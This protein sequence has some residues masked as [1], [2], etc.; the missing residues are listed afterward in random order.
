[1]K[2]KEQN[3]SD[4]SK[5]IYLIYGQTNDDF[6]EPSLEDLTLNE[7][8]YLHLK[9]LEYERI[10]Y[11]NLSRKLFFF[12]VKSKTT[13]KNVE[14]PP[15][16]TNKF[17][18]SIVSGPLGGALPV[19]H[20]ESLEPVNNT[21]TLHFGKMSD[22]HALKRINAVLHDT[23]S[24]TA[25]I[26]ENADDYIRFFNGPNLHTLGSY[27][28]SWEQL[29]KENQ[30]I[31][32]LVFPT[33][34]S[35]QDIV[36][37]YQ[38]HSVFDTY[39]KKYLQKT[40]KENTVEIK[41]PVKAEMRNVC[42]YLRIVYKVPFE[43]REFDQVIDYLYKYVMSEGCSLKEITMQLIYNKSSEKI[44]IAYLQKLFP[45]DFSEDVIMEINSLIGQNNFKEEVHKLIKKS[46]KVNKSYV[47]NEL[48]FH[49]R[50]THKKT[51]K[52]K[53]E[54]NL[55][56]ALLG[57]P[58]T[59][60]T[61]VAKKMGQL[62]AKLGYLPSG[63]L[64]KATRADLV[65]E[66]V[67]HTAPK[68]QK[69][70]NR[71][72]GGVLFIDEVYSLYKGEN[73][74]FGKECID[75][76]VDNL[77]EHMGEFSLVIAGYP[78][79]V[80][81]FIRTSNEGLR[82]RF[83][84]QIVIEDYTDLE[85]NEI[86]HYHIQK[87]NYKTT[88]ALKRKTLPIFKDLYESGHSQTTNAGAPMKLIDSLFENWSLRDDAE[89]LDGCPLLDEQDIPK[90][91]QSVFSDRG[92]IDVTN[93][94]KQLDQMIGLDNVKSVIKK[95][96]ANLQ[97]SDHRITPGHYA[98]LGNPG[99]GKTS[100]A[101]IMADIFKKIG[102][103]RTGNVFEVSAKD[104]TGSYEGSTRKKT[105]NVLEKALGGVLIIDEAYSLSR[106]SY[107]I[108]T[109]DEIV[110]FMEDHKQNITII[111]TGY[112]KEM[113][114]FFSSNSGLYSRISNKVDFPDYTS[115][116]LLEILLLLV[117]EYSLILPE[118]LHQ[119][120]VQ[121]FYDVTA[122][123][124]TK[125]GNARYVREL[126]EQTKANKN[127]RLMSIYGN[128]KAVPEEEFSYIKIDD[129]P[130]AT[131]S[132]I[133][134]STVEE[135]LNI[136]NQMIGLNEVKKEVSRIM[137]NIQLS[138]DTVVPGHYAFIG[139]PGTGKTTVARI[140]GNIYKHLN[141][142][143]SGKVVEVSASDF[144]AGYTGQTRLKTQEVLKNALGGVLIIDEAYSIAGTNAQD[145]FG[146]QALDEIIKFMEDNR[147]HICIIFAGYKKEM[148][149]FFNAN[150]GLV[151]RIDNQIYFED[152]NAEELLH[153][154]QLLANQMKI[155]LSE[156]FIERCKEI[157]LSE[158]VLN[159]PH[160]GNGRFIRT[161]LNNAIKEM[162]LRLISTYNLKENIPVEELR[163]LTEKDLV[164]G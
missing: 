149:E 123:Q 119:E 61:T 13:T 82:R 147:Q 46:D 31:V 86:F 2:F 138:N 74:V 5:R 64:V 14:E 63:H 130:F 51:A 58:G 12:D 16:I 70:I 49:H 88:Q 118:D 66:Y 30:N 47:K 91:Y 148:T 137:A 84:Q 141:I 109:I 108:Q 153:I 3:F 105:S 34:Y 117:K 21:E 154:T 110:K 69:V 83:K 157:F 111:F 38:G 75:L 40:N 120:W 89:E 100:I 104:F 140:I 7:V 133:K 4:P 39:F 113:E 95:V 11:F 73:D 92:D 44:N 8:L 90:E 99:T 162:N 65:G 18:S 68:T 139:N 52:K 96:I 156:D 114:E 136:L 50:V 155:T 22:S 76:L 78:K 115:S 94:L 107:G 122:T 143:S 56:Y 152:Y 159:N 42:N 60:K 116:E 23:K 55:H 41:N 45:F 128:R 164:K 85:L 17:T 29:P 112:H 36:Q 101:R 132:S 72:L 98:F 54:F 9:E 33:V 121:H 25:V 19:N 142:L 93:S 125:F 80:E 161:L 124:Q 1:M 126:L 106:D 48:I 158:Q 79:Q 87:R 150:S 53:E 6:Y 131:T 59:G 77:T 144:I 103:L 67:G 102:L 129:L 163:L 145:T 151:S 97:M 10:V 35:K 37:K 27:F 127:L 26:F 43:M 135:E 28:R 24:K 32:L 15:R 146:Q 160:F 134:E 81:E 20:S 71:A 57:N 62:F